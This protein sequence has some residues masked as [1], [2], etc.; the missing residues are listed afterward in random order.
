MSRL[1]GI[2]E[3]IKIVCL[4]HPSP[5]PMELEQN[6]ELFKSPFYACTERESMHC[7]NRL[8]IDDYQELILSFL[9]KVGSE[10]DTDFTG[11]TFSYRGPRQKVNAKVVTYNDIEIVIGV[12]NETVLGKNNAIKLSKLP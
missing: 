10:P 6:L 2:W 11:Y 7:P 9:D 5:V 3:K 1:S 12:Y 4:N 8:N